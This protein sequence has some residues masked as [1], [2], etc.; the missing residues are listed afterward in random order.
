MMLAM[1]QKKSS[2]T[3][4]SLWRDGGMNQSIRLEMLSK[5]NE[6]SYYATFSWKK[7]PHLIKVN[8]NNKTWKG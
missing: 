5:I 1:E 4:E 7:L 8:L 3:A 2:V 6:G